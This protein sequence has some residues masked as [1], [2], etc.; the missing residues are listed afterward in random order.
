MSAR[1][2]EDQLV[3]E[4][5]RREQAGERAADTAVTIQTRQGG[6][7]LREI[8]P[9]VVTRYGGTLPFDS[10]GTQLQDGQ[11]VTDNNGDMNIR[12]NMEAIFTYSELVELNQMRSSEG[13]LF[14]VS[15][16]YSGPATFDQLK[17]D[18]IPDENGRVQSDGDVKRTA[19]YSV[20]LQSQEQSNNDIGG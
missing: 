8:S 17:Y 5:D 7:V 11:T 20:Q 9:D 3:T 2:I 4:Q 1:D 14:V 16:S 10:T 19:T 18:R 15:P 6:R 13:Q 12:L